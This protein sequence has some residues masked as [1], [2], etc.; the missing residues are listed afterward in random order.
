MCC[1]YLATPFT[2][3]NPQQYAIAGVLLV[4]GVVLWA[5]TA[6]WNKPHNVRPLGPGV[7][8]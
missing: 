5:F 8:I 3:R 4:V 1:A 7:D 6:L 2:D